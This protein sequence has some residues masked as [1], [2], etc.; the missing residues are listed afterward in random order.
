MNISL[1]ARNI[2][3]QIIQVNDSLASQIQ[4]PNTLCNPSFL[5][6]NNSLT[7]QITQT[8]ENGVIYFYYCVQ[9]TVAKLIDVNKNDGSHKFTDFKNTS[10]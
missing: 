7:L 5:C 3:L 6:K 2:G 9:L 10:F 4:Q 8:F 1:K